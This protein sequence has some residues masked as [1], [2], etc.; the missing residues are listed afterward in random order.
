MLSKVWIVTCVSPVW[1]GQNGTVEEV[2]SG[3]LHRSQ[4]VKVRSTKRCNSIRYLTITPVSEFK[5]S[6]TCKSKMLVPE[7]IGLRSLLRGQ[8]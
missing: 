8:R 7:A 4:G 3:V 2:T 6:T 1:L 5:K